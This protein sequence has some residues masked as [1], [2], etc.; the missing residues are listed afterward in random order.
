LWLPDKAQ[1]RMTPKIVSG[2][3]SSS[4]VVPWTLLL[5]QSQLMNQFNIQPV[6]SAENIGAITSL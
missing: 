5:L 1:L 3:P 4:D 6:P 2:I